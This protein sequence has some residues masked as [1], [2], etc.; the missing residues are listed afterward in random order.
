MKF[1]LDKEIN[2]DETDLLH[3]SSYSSAL[4]DIIKNAPKDISF[5]IGLFGEW[6][7]GK[8]SI[9]KTVSDNFNADKKNKVK[10]ILYD[11]WKYSEDSFRRMFLLQIQQDLKFDKTQKFDSFYRSKS[12]DVK[13]DRKVD[14][15]YIIYT[16]I[17]FII[18]FILIQF[19]R[20]KD[21]DLKLTVTLIVSFLAILINILGRAFSDYKIAV[22]EPMI[23]AP[24]QFEECFNEMIDL[25]LKKD[26]KI[27]S[28]IKWVKGD[29]YI[30]GLDKV[31]IV[32]DNIDRCPKELA[33]E[34]ITNIKN[35]LGNKKNLVF[36]IPVDDEALKRHIQKDG[37]GNEKESEEFLRKFFNVTLRIKPFK[38]FDLYDFTNDINKANKLNLSP[39]TIDIISKEYATNPRRIIQFFNNLAAELGIFRVKYKDEF[40][41]ENE[42]L[43]CKMLI[44]REEWPDYYK[45][46]A[47]NPSLLDKPNDELVKSLTERRD[48]SSFLSV[49]DSITKFK[50]FDVVEK[51][52]SITDRTAL[53]SAELVEK[54][55]KKDIDGLVNAVSNSDIERKRLVDFLIEKLS[56]S[57]KRQTFQTDSNN[58][59]EIICT[60]NKHYSLESDEHNR[61]YYEI[62]SHLDSFL[63]HINDFKIVCQYSNQLLKTDDTYLDTWIRRYFISGISL[64]QKDE[65]WYQTSSRIFRA[66]IAEVGDLNKL[67]E[68]KQ[69]FTFD[70]DRSKILLKDYELSSE[71]LQALKSFDL[72]DYLANNLSDFEQIDKAYSELKLLSES[73]Q[74]DNHE[75]EILFNRINQIYPDLGGKEKEQIIQLLQNINPLFKN[76]KIVLNGS[77]KDAVIKFHSLVIGG[78]IIRGILYDLLD[79]IDS[80]EQVNT[81]IDFLFVTYRLTNGS[82]SIIDSLNKLLRRFDFVFEVINNKIIALKNIG[83]YKLS[84]L[85]EIIKQD[86][87]YTDQRLEVLEHVFLLKEGNDFVVTDEVLSLKLN[88]ILMASLDPEQ[89]HL[90]TFLKKLS[91]NERIKTVLQKHISSLNKEQI[92]ALSKELQVL[93]FDQI[94]EGDKIFEY[95]DSLEFLKAMAANGEKTHISRLIKLVVNKLTQEEKVSEG[96]LI[97]QEI[98][99]LDPTDKRMV[100][101]VI[102]DISS[103]DL[104]KEAKEILKT[105]N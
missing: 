37:N 85:V 71:R 70:Y 57:F 95:S 90:Q 59:F 18:G 33:Y 27:D 1:I 45:L 44:L 87:P 60:L 72:V 52:L 77:A 79:Q 28:L 8:S 56:I 35:F 78:R 61:I 49:T 86:Q 19:I 24:E 76:Q 83:G 32:V 102:D 3:T 69:T 104:K 29:N 20:D 88:L 84:P 25:A 93:A 30:S 101:A 13:I 43:I 67:E 7:S 81:L 36:L 99:S 17:A 55:Q 94:A 64:S 4:K 15:R 41:K 38:R 39:T 9:I 53:I 96:V 58:I 97:L 40:V 2:L 89:D 105:I 63:P 23:F 51:I 47:L 48:L 14:Y 73:V 68:L 11:A 10:F 46:I 42:S 34:L 92:L 75:I 21:Q 80:D 50:N 22:Q 91:N 98:K 54:I 62:K 100:E 6:G 5:T 26:S 103:Q 65:T 74:F 82:V 66:Y 31:V 16:G 12:S